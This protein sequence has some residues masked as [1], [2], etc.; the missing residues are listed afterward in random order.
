MTY[1]ILSVLVVF[2][3][4]VAVFSAAVAGLAQFSQWG[5]KLRA[6]NLRCGVAELIH[7]V[8]T[9]KRHPCFSKSDARRDATL[10]LAT[11]HADEVSRP[12]PS[13]SARAPLPR[14]SSL[15][16]SRFADVLRGTL[17]DLREYADEIAARFKLLERPLEKRFGRLVR[18]WTVVWASALAFSMQ[19]STPQLI[20]SLRGDLASALAAL[21]PWP[22]GVEFFVGP[23]GLRADAILG[24]LVSVVLLTFGAP[25][26]SS[27][28]GRRIGRGDFKPKND[29]ERRGDA[30]NEHPASQP[31]ANNEKLIGDPGCAIRAL[32]FA[33][34]GFDTL[35]HLGVTHALLV[36]QGRAPDAVVGLSEGAIQ[37]AALAEIL[38]AG[39]KHGERL[40]RDQYVD[41]LK[42]RVERF[43]EFLHA[44]HD[45]PEKLLDSLLP[46]AYEIDARRP[47]LPL[48]M[49]IFAE[50]EREG[51]KEALSTKS[52]LVRLYNDLLSI[53]LPFGTIARGI[54]RI[55]GLRAVA[56]VRGMPG[57]SSGKRARL[58]GF[59]LRLVVG[60][61]EAFRVWLL[62][63]QDLIRAV[64]LVRI[65]LRPLIPI[66][67][68]PR[69]ST[70]GSLIFRFR[71]LERTMASAVNILVFLLILTIWVGVS[72]A[73]LSF[74]A[75]VYLRT[76]G[77]LEYGVWLLLLYGLP[78]LYA[79]LTRALKHHEKTDRP[80]G[81]VLD[82]GKGVFIFLYLFVK[83]AVLFLLINLVVF[84]FLGQPVLLEWGVP[85]FFEWGFRLSHWIS[86]R[87]FVVCILA[88]VVVYLVP[89]W[90]SKRQ[91]RRPVS[92]TKKYIH[93]FLASYYLDGALS[94]AHHLEHFLAGLF[95][96]RYYGSIDFDKVIDES[97]ADRTNP[98]SR[99]EEEDLGAGRKKIRD[100]AHRKDCRP[101]HVGLAVADVGSGRL[102]TVP[103][104]QSVV[105]G[106]LAATAVAPILPPRRIGADLC[107]DG[108]NVSNVPTRALLS[109]LRRR[110]N[111]A[112][113]IVHIY[114]VSPFPMSKPFQGGIVDEPPG[115]EGDG[116]GYRNLID[117]ALRAWEL[118]RY[119]DATLEWR[120]TELYTK[121]IPADRLV[122]QGRRSDDLY[123][124]A[125]VT[126][127]E[128]DQRLHLN[129][130]LLFSP[131]ED[132]EVAINRAVADGCRAALEVMLR[133][134]LAVAETEE[135]ESD[136]SILRCCDAVQKHKGLRAKLGG[137]G[138]VDL[139]GSRK[140]RAPGLPEICEN[141]AIDRTADRNR[142]Q[143]HLAVKKWKEVGPAWPHEMEK[144]PEEIGRDERF[145]PVARV[146]QLGSQIEQLGALADTNWPRGALRTEPQEQPRVKRPVVS[147]LFSG[148]V[149]RGVFQM[150]VLNALNELGIQP[151]VIAGASVGSITAAMVARAFSMESESERRLQIAR[152]ASV[153]LAVDRLIL[154]DRFAD[155]VRNVTIRAAEM[156]FSLKDAD[157]LF[158]K[159]DYPGPLEFDPNA[160]R[161]IAGIERLLYVNPYQLNSFVR[162]LRS[163]DARPTGDHLRKFVQQWLTRMEVREEILGA[164]PLASLIRF[165]VLQEESAAQRGDVPF[166]SFLREEIVLLATTTNLTRGKLEILRGPQPRLVEGLLSSSAFPGVFRPRRSSDLFPG[167]SDNDQFIDGGV[168]DNLPIEAV[169][170]FLVRAA[171]EKFIASRPTISYRNETHPV[172]HLIFAASLEP[173]T[174]DTTYQGR[175]WLDL[176]RRAGELGYNTKTGIFTT[177]EKN[178]RAIYSQ[179]LEEQ[180]RP[181][182]AAK[183]LEPLD[184]E[185]VTVK[186]AWLPGTFAFHPMLGFRRRRQAQSIAHGCAWT[187]LR[188]A[189][190]HTTYRRAWGIDAIATPKKSG[191]Q[192]ARRHWH[193]QREAHDKDRCWLRPDRLCPFSRTALEKLNKSTSAEKPKLRKT[194]I[195]E[196]HAIHQACLDPLT[197]VPER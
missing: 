184:L 32:N 127:I 47:L 18:V 197:H 49:P 147:L 76:R 145:V 73:L 3:G 27:V 58:L 190:T 152:L 157:R 25:I 10:V 177:A 138:D 42:A 160:R 117:I 169:I 60:F 102:K 187:L 1:Q 78:F 148:G 5:I 100:Y 36:I 50:N 61:I 52:G 59:W 173:D 70:A 156:R 142:H 178:I 164:E 150:G 12:I 101:I 136:T 110:I 16:P 175:N 14:I 108:K 99:G 11:V 65:L 7:T 146:G 40:N 92:L 83:W 195:E 129:R 111:P 131:K 154:T 104:D 28:L 124:R 105:G 48:E 15:D 19:L 166:N 22:H 26:L 192:E 165:Y 20:E 46:D 54:R 6:R 128:L 67:R 183:G 163:R 126:P 87:V 196:L 103:S 189:D 153:Y 39:G 162:T 132:S 44:S 171:E 109:M 2:A 159:Y 4:V 9:E 112:S 64:P 174:T 13:R 35:M 97:L 137:L 81:L 85:E 141:C 63:G 91:G 122:T 161:V 93:R 38:Q 74:P 96:H 118:K 23:S 139:P 68:R 176:L 144:G 80:W 133:K 34:G 143:R 29:S 56:E 45:A 57:K 30:V 179:L 158:R 82:T 31:V 55:L 33:G 94:T 95:D 193:G 155:F 188:F 186:P 125:W 185:V 182:P 51:R 72:W 113:K 37:A 79:L 116:G 167:T 106:L 41:V 191:L 180:Q 98:S 66:S 140:Q 62:V 194:T 168:M 21:Q 24:V 149:F 69:A 115:K 86:L 17:P 75:W 135:S 43:R 172:P 53:D 181:G 8:R 88:V 77:T 134:S 84:F 123:F 89:H 151:D 121:I 114:S 71:L 170:R 130:Q 120:L 107:V 90:W 119:R